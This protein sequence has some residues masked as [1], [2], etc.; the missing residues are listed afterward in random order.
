MHF[1]LIARQNYMRPETD[2]SRL[3]AFALKKK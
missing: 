1:E 2:K 3:K